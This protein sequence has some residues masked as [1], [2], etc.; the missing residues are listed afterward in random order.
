ME[1]AGIVWKDAM[2]SQMAQ[3]A[4]EE[5]AD[6]TYRRRYAQYGKLLL[7]MMRTGNYYRDV[8]GAP[9]WPDPPKPGESGI[10]SDDTLA[11]A[12]FPADYNLL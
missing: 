3:R 4:R 10:V 2:R 9:R 8:D 6:P 11:F 5:E 1:R 7:W 12:R